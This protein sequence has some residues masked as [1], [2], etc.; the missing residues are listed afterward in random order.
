MIPFRVSFSQC[1]GTATTLS[2][3]QDGIRCDWP[4]RFSSPLLSSSLHVHTV[5]RLSK[6]HSQ[7]LTMTSIIPA[8]TGLDPKTATLASLGLDL[9]GIFP[10]SADLVP[11]IIF[12]VLVSLAH[13]VVPESTKS[14]YAVSIPLL[15]YRFTKP[16]TRG[17]LARTTIFLALRLTQ[18]ILRALQAKYTIASIGII[19]QC[20]SARLHSELTGQSPSWSFSPSRRSS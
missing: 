19:G 13:H 9:Y 7:I 14:Q 15:V 20:P 12:A 17:I 4:S 8:S 16:G 5:T 2:S 11:S 10:T 18:L 1:G 3:R 6:L